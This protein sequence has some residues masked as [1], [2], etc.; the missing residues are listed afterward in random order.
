[1]KF[2]D[3]AKK[4]WNDTKG[5]LAITAVATTLAIAYLY[6]RHVNITNL[7]LDEHNLIEEFYKN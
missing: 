5:P 6:G 7:F 4:L 3:K 1:M 2:K